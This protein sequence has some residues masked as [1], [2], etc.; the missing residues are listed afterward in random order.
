MS[1]N[2]IPI[3]DLSPILSSG[4]T[5]PSTENWG[6]V[7]NEFQAALSILMDSLLLQIITFQMPK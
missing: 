5:E 1:V 6:K 3:V 2:C 7:A 4:A